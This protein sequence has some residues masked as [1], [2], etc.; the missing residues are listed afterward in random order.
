MPDRCTPEYE[1]IL[2]KMGA[3]L[4]Y[5]RA[6]DLL[7]ELF[8]LDD[9][10]VVETIRQRTLHVGRSLEREATAAK[11][12][13][14]AAKAA[15]FVVLSI[16]GGH[17]R[18]V[19]SYQ[20]RSFEVFIAQ[21]SNDRGH[22]IVFSSIPAEADRQRQQLANILRSLGATVE[23]PITILSD[24]AQGPCYLA[25]RD[26]EF[27][28]DW[29]HLSMRIQHVTQTIKIWPEVTPNDIAVGAQFC[30]CYRTYPLAPL[31]RT[32]GQSVGS[33]WR[34]AGVRLTPRSSAS[35]LPPL[36]K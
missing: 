14:S 11:E 8:P 4:P 18:S 12:Q 30:R 10:P 16:D 5:R 9:A 31:A 27:V 22:Q 1:R 34:D 2:T 3:F 20:A 35:V 32:S 26:G 33:D 24:G 15:G 13:S 25:G 19:H 17:V 28:L 23:T 21:A 7:A 6:A 29:F 36:P